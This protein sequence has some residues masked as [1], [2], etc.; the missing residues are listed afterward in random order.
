MRKSFVLSMSVAVFTFS[1]I[2][3]GAQQ[4]QSTKPDRSVPKTIT[5]I[6]CVDRADQLNAGNPDTTV[7][8]LS[9]VLT[10]ASRDGEAASS[11]PTADAHTRADPGL[12]YRLDGA[13]ATLN[14]H[15]GHKVQVTGA[16]V[17]IATGTSGSTDPVS[18]ANAARLK[19]TS[20]KMLAE[21]C[22]R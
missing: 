12:M 10:H 15:V 19:V 11:K 4:S 18:P 3:L 21:T 1:A 5:V 6:G 22:A 17:A 9:F 16:V 14:P 7:D 20:I 13:V 8:S 2:G